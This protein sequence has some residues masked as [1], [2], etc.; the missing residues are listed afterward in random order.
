MLN[1][2]IHGFAQGVEVDVSFA[3]TNAQLRVP[4][5]DV[6]TSELCAPSWAVNRA[7]RKRAPHDTD[8]LSGANRISIVTPNI[9]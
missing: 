6:A 1:V 7:S 2:E 5:A 4:G 8:P 3:K 9:S